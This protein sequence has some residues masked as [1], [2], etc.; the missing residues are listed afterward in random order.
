M[1]LT[2]NSYG[3]LNA[4]TQSYLETYLY[5]KRARPTKNEPQQ[6]ISYL[7][8]E[9]EG[10]D[11]E[12]KEV[13]ERERWASGSVGRIFKV[14]FGRKRE[15]EGKDRDIEIHTNKETELTIKIPSKAG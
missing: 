5:N 14:R 3:G 12:R 15:K 2:Y 8:R 11:R 1:F 10:W 4:I 6:G 7:E 9:R 13:R